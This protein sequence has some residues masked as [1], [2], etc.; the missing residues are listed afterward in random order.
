MRTLT[1]EE[2]LQKAAENAR[3][4]LESENEQLKK[5]MSEFKKTMYA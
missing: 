1:Q 5:A 2:R 4:E 3:R